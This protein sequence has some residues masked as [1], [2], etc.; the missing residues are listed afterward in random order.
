MKIIFYS[1]HCEYSKKMIAYLEKYNIKHLFKLIDINSNEVPKYIDIVPTIVDSDLNLPL[2]GKSAFEYLVNIKY[3]NNPTNNI[4]YQNKIPPNPTIVE[5]DKANVI[6]NNNLSICKELSNNEL[7]TND[8][9]KFYQNNI[10]N[11]V[12]KNTTDMVQSRSIQDSK[13][14]ILLKMKRKST[15]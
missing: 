9:L 2:K 4:E 10:N 15:M 14:S 7:N 6:N 11:S 12:S 3:F 13:L 8:S 1:E 5:D